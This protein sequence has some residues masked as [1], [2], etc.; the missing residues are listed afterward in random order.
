MAS[1]TFCEKFSR[2]FQGLSCLSQLYLF[3]SIARH[4]TCNPP[5]VRFRFFVP[6]LKIGQWPNGKQECVRFAAKHPPVQLSFKINENRIALEFFFCPL[7]EQSPVAYQTF[8][9]NVQNLRR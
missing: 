9:S 8:M 3:V 7:T 4:I 2:I 6:A 5:F 1:C